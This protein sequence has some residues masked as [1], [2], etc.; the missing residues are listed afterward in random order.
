MRFLINRFVVVQT[1]EAR[2]ESGEARR[3]ME[4]KKNITL[5]KKISGDQD[6]D[7]TLFGA[8]LTSHASRLFEMTQMRDKNTR[9]AALD[10][11][12]H[13][14][15]Q[16][17]VNPNEA[18]PFLFALQGDVEEDRIRS[19][20]LKLLM[21]EGEKRPD[22]LR[23]R[24]CAG[25]KQAYLFQK[26]VY[27][28]RA[29]VSALVDVNRNGKLQKECVLGSVYKECIQSIRKQRQGLF[30]NM[31]SLFSIE[32][33]EDRSETNGKKSKKAAKE[34]TSQSTDLALL[35]FSAQVLA[36]L[37]FSAAADPL[38]IIHS[39][40][41]MLALQGPDLLDRLASFL[42]PYG[43]ASTDEM[44]ENNLSE[45]NIETAAR[46]NTPRHAKEIT[47]LLEPDFDTKTF[48]ELCCDAG[49]LT[50]LLRLKDYLKKCYNLSEI[51][52]LEY[53]PDAKERMSEKMIS[54]GNGSAVFD[55][56]LPLQQGDANAAVDLDGM[57]FQYTEFRQRMRTEASTDVRMDDDDDS[58][59]EA[60]AENSSN[61]RKRD[62]EQ[63]VD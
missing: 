54:R 43:L 17:Q 23:Q 51:R 61:K 56:Y 5:S 31:L 15:R 13:L 4:S 21:I 10:L 42:R 58:E 25:V 57:I 6:G 22:M 30:R 47:R 8:V 24:A 45:D 52:C 53:N 14:L 46:R 33:V 12:G 3:V 18:T 48:L 26:L 62:E 59:D 60:R 9:F 32:T 63:E 41:S 27:P 19:L 37:P 40:S 20:G 28:D 34:S 36:Y 44:D 39:I 38:Y 1:E 55:A 7:A 49:L 16:G 2:I 29:E 50:L 11:I 35:S